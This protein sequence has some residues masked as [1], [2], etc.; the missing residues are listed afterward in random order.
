MSSERNLRAKNPD[1]DS[2]AFING[3][4]DYETRKSYVKKKKRKKKKKKR[5]LTL[6][7]A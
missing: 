1:H 3:T 5:L 7:L 4:Q 6:Q 2:R